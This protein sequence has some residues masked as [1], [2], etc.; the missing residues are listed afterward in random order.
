MKKIIVNWILS[1]V[2]ILI[3]AY[4]L[5]GIGLANLW[6]AFVAALVLGILNA[7]VRPLLLIL[8]LPINILTLG[9]FTFIINAMV[10]SLA[11]SL[12]PGFQVASF[13]WAILF[14]IILSLV[15]MGINRFRKE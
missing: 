1:T 5:P 14:S 15:N 2:A 8:T 6:A 3:A 13:G 4:L 12:V 11:A 7:V 9:L 10:V